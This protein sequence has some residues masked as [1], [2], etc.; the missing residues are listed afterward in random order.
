MLTA[1]AEQFLLWLVFTPFAS[2][3]T[4]L[5]LECAVVIG[6]ING[7]MGDSPEWG[8]SIVKSGRIRDSETGGIVDTR[9]A[10]RGGDN[11]AGAITSALDIIGGDKD[12]GN[13]VADDDDEDEDDDE[14]D[15][16]MD[17]RSTP[18]LES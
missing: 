17:S 5:L 8:A 9:G 18:T 7:I 3:L 2:T 13:I 15:S 4:A 16:H 11:G 12:V 14:E 10:T 6:T 1:V